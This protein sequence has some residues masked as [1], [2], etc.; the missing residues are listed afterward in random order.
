ML[1]IAAVH[2]SDEIAALS[3]VPE[4][5]AI[6]LWQVLE[7]LPHPFQ[8]LEVASDRLKPGGTLIVAMPN[9]DSFQSR[10]LGAKWA[11]L[12][13]PRHVV[14]I[15][16]HLLLQEALRVGLRPIL[17]TTRDAGSIAWNRFGWEFSFRNIFPD[18]ADS[19]FAIKLGKQLGELFRFIDDREGHGAAYTA[20]LRKPLA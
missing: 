7:H 2:A 4:V 11:H 13:A 12:D 16:H 17:V 15:S 14:L 10:M 9:P 20:V 18:L 3:R 1:G 6:T 19:G 8:L 5:D